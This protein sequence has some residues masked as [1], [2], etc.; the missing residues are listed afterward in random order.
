M[1]IVPFCRPGPGR[2]VLGWVVGLA[3]AAPG[4]QAVRAQSSDIWLG[5]GSS[6]Q[7]SGLGSAPLAGAPL[8]TARQRIP[9]FRFAPGF[10]YEPIGLRDEDDSPPWAV[11]T[12]ASLPEPDSGPD[13]IQVAMG[14]DNP[15]FDFRQRGDP[16]GFGYFR[17]F[18]Q[19]Q[20]LD[21]PHT[22]CA[23]NMQAISPAGV[24]YWGVTNGPTMVSPAFALFHALDDDTALQGFVSKNLDVE[25]AALTPAPVQRSLHYG[26]AV[27]RALAPDGP[28]GLSNVYFYLGA[29]G[30]YQPNREAMLYQPAA[31][32]MLPG[33]HWRLSN[34][35]WLSGGV[36]VPVGVGR[37]DG[38]LPW[39][40]TWSMQF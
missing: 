26:M 14:S 33:L 4:P 10:L 13:W 15:Y 11:S 29:L 36:L 23:V 1:R 19:V 28:D 24:Q 7:D 34:T 17:L 9:I 6:L 20:L 35:S 25:H 2:A 3:F 32:K 30:W 8:G 40:F 21:T 39:Q 22:S 18:T 12:P 38:A 37:P 5:N 31:L 16:G 27:Q